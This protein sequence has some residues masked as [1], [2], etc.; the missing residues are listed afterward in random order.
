[1][2]IDADTSYHYR[3]MLFGD[4]L[5][6]F[7]IFKET[8]YSLK[9]MFKFGAEINL[10]NLIQMSPECRE[11]VRETNRNNEQWTST[12]PGYGKTLKHNLLE[13]LNEISLIIANMKASAVDII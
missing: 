10:E 9:S 5:E 3:G 13:G 8:L 4:P 11:L 7:S 6:C 1:V 2:D 12:A